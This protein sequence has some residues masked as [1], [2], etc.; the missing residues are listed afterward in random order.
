MS[1]FERSALWQTWLKIRGHRKVGAAVSVPGSN[2]AARGLGGLR[3]EIRRV[4]RKLVDVSERL[5]P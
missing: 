2:P 3:P 1:N 5:T 4:E